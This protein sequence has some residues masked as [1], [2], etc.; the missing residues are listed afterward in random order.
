MFFYTDDD[1]AS[2]QQRLSVTAAVIEEEEHE[3]ARK[4]HDAESLVPMEAEAAPASAVAV[5]ETPAR[6]LSPLIAQLNPFL[7]PP[8]LTL[9]EADELGAA[10]S[11]TPLFEGDRG[12][13]DSSSE[14]PLRTEMRE[15]VCRMQQC[16][17]SLTLQEVDT[18]ELFAKL[19][20]FQEFADSAEL[21]PR[22][23]SK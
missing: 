11:A 17:L 22:S 19:A 8:P 10:W 14:H 4:P 21:R 9:P 18:E 6:R 16:Q 2:A 23:A 1:K 7:S 12:E 15:L 3:D 13:E 20:H 5:E